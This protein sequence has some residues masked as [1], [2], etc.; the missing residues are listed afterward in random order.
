MSLQTYYS[1]KYEIADPLVF[2]KAPI[3]HTNSSRTE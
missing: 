3:I 1:Q 2:N